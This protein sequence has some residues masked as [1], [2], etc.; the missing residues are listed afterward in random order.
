MQ[1]RSLLVFVLAVMAAPAWPQPAPVLS[2]Y[3]LPLKNAEL[4]PFLAA[5]RAV[6]A[7]PASGAAA[8]DTT[9]LDTR[10]AGVPALERMTVTAREGR[11]LQV[12]FVVKAYGQDNQA[13]RRALLDKYGPPMTVSPRPLPF[14]GFGTT[15]APRGAFQWR[16]AEG[17]ALVWQHPRLGD[18]TLTYLDETRAAAAPETPAAAGELRNRF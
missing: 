3:G 6:G 9:V 16:F 13:L 8:A 17:M 11:V 12:Q 7:V 1:R 10:N 4:G 14:G 2:L 18:V 15:A 5:A